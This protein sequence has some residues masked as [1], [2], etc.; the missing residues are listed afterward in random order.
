MSH[1]RVADPRE[2]DAI[3]RESHEI[4]GGGLN[5]RDYQQLWEDLAATPWGRDHMTLLVWTDADNRIL[6]SM[7][8][9]RPVIRCSGRESRSAVIGAVFT[10]RRHRRHGHAAAM[11]REV[12]RVA[13]ERGD[14]P[15]LLFS[16]VGVRY[17]ASLGFHPLP[18]HECWGR[19]LQPARPTGSR[20][21]LRPVEDA[22]MA[23]VMLAHETSHRSSTLAMVR[24]PG[25][26]EFLLVRSR[27]FF[28]RLARDD[29]AHRFSVA[30]DGESFVGYVIA[31]ESGREWSVRE[32]G[33]LDGEPDT[34]VRVLRAASV[35]ARRRGLRTLHGWLPRSLT[36]RLSEWRIRREPR[37]R[38]IP[39]V[40]PLGA[41]IDPR[42]LTD[43]D[44]TFFAFMDQF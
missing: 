2:I 43:P 32:V 29:V 9:Y 28:R 30:L 33:S 37:H 23:Q 22:D 27:S 36:E 6:S 34:M 21:T 16:D 42:G 35:P 18:A 44:D 20:L 12:L 15:A 3:Y 31:V 38:A 17:Y 13:E 41:A 40:A 19:L 8:L 25:H 14:R 39:M 24:D 26:W 7:K 5:R 4:W 1:L 10:P 11:L